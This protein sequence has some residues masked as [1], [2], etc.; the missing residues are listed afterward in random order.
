MPLYIQKY[1][2][3]SMGSIERIKNVAMRIKKWSD[4]G[5]QLVIVTSAMS[6][7]T[8]RLLNLAYSLTSHT[9]SRE[10]DMLVSTGEQVSAALLAIALN[11]LGIPTVS[12]AGWQIAMKTTSAYTRARI[13][14]VDAQRIRQDLASKRIVVITGF[15]GV[16]ENGNITTLGRGGS[17][18]S[19]VAIAAAVH[20]DECQIFTD[21]DGVYTTDPRVVKN[22]RR[23]NYITFEEV[24]EM[25]S[26]G[27]KVL[28]TRSVELAV[29]YQVKTRV[30]SS[31]TDPLLP[32][33]IEKDAGTLITLEQ[34]K[35]NMENAVI[36]G[37][38]FQRDEAQ[39]V[40]VGV[41]DKP[42]V[43]ACILSPIAEAMIEVDMIIQTKGDNSKT[44]FTFTVGKNDYEKAC[45][46]LSEKQMI[47]G[48][49]SITGDNNVAKVSVVG[50]GMRS[51]VGITSRIFKA[52]AE[53]N[54]N[55][56]S[57]STSEIK[58]S[59]LIERQFLERAVNILH[60]VFKL[61]A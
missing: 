22:A 61:D 44:N 51:D 21:V 2:G 60:T 40:L 19:A 56:Q 24:L 9:N 8:D 55:I 29:K 39:I 11:K 34:K 52:L 23:L 28:Q 26:L 25:A 7:E 15:Q 58:V 46:I 42:G 31:L 43:A 57:I 17:D 18:T 5:H 12:Y 10:L 30:L 13:L 1:G 4:A 54:I 53:E 59:I 16:D 50:V 47:I 37:I 38:A 45:Q 3:T 41:P 48:A 33:S 49:A 35:S 6:G 14:N 27:S 32:L 36:S 20:A